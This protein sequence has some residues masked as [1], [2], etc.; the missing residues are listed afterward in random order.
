[1]KAPLAG[2]VLSEL[3]PVVALVGYQKVVVGSEIGLNIVAFASRL[4]NGDTLITDS[5]NNRIAEVNQ[6]GRRIRIPRPT[7]A[8]T[9]RAAAEPQTTQARRP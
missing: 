4:K 8:T 5:G 6:P 9:L 3:L 7:A 1:V 2:E